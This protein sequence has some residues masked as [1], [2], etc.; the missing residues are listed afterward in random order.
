MNMNLST[1]TISNFI[2]AGLLVTAIGCAPAS[3]DATDTTSSKNSIQNVEVVNPSTNSFIAETVVAGTAEPNRSVMLYAMEGG[4]VEKVHKDIGDQVHKGE[5]IVELRNPE[6]YR[7]KQQLEAELEGKKST[8]ERLES[9][10]AKTPALTPKQILEDARAAYLSAQAKLDG[11]TDRIGFLY[12]RAPFSGVLTARNVDEGALVQSGMSNS[13]ATA[14]VEI[15]E[16]NPIRLSIPLPGSDAAAIGVGMEALVSFPELAG[17]AFHANVSRTS[18]SFDRDSRTMLVE[19]DIDNA[20][21]KIK[22]GMYAKVSMQ[23]A[24]RENVM[25]LPVTAQVIVKGQPCVLV[26]EDGLVRLVELKKGLANKDYF[27][28][29]ND[30]IGAQA[31]VIVK[32][33]GLVK[34]GDTVK[35]VNV[36]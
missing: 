36:K 7:Q 23:I 33:K 28:V 22:P 4:M 16:N 10:Y 27:E 34:A 26:V 25:T 24:S 19:I 21:G 29:L 6:L 18:N 3:K 9:S 31:Q 11:V 20:D 35:A 8:Y 14:L 30:D 32:G 13:N 1:H 12:V 2:V 17:Q 5:T 15:Q